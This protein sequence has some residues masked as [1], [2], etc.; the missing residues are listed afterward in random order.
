M[1]EEA[2]LTYYAQIARSHGYEVRT[3]P[4]IT[5]R[6]GTMYGIN[7][8]NVILSG[9]EALVPHYGIEALDRVGRKVYEDLG[10]DVISMDSTANSICAWGGIR[11][12]SE[13]YRMSNPKTP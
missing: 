1:R 9:K 3:V 8:T 11:C 5:T 12:A 7:Y 4:G 6:E 13:T 2:G 10:Y